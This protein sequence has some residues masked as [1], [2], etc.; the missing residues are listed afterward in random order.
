MMKLCS[1]CRY[2]VPFTH[3]QDDGH[4]THTALEW[5]HPVSGAK[6]FPLAFTQRNSVTGCGMK[7]QYWEFN[8]GSSPEPGEQED[9]G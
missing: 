1:D 2:F 6:R 9:M 5:T 3:T 4:C 7:A 8:P